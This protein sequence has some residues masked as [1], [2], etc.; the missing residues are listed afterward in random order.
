MNEAL[1]CYLNHDALVNYI[2][3]NVRQGWIGQLGAEINKLTEKL[4]AKQELIH[5]KKE[6]FAKMNQQMDLLR[7]R[8]KLA[9]DA[10]MQKTQVIQAWNGIPDMAM[11]EKKFADIVCMKP[12][13]GKG[14]CTILPHKMSPITMYYYGDVADSNILSK[15]SGPLVRVIDGFQQMNP[16]ELM[17]MTLIDLIGGAMSLRMDSRIKWSTRSQKN[18]VEE[19]VDDGMMLV[20]NVSELNE[21]S[22]MIERHGNMLVEYNGKHSN[23]VR[24][25]LGNSGTISGIAQANQIRTEESLKPFPY[26][27]VFI[28]VP[29]ANERDEFSYGQ[30]ALQRF[31]QDENISKAYGILPVFIVNKDS[32]HES[33]KRIV[34]HNGV[35]VTLEPEGDSYHALSVYRSK[36]KLSGRLLLQPDRRKG[37][38]DKSSGVLQQQCTL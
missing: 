20:S 4:N 18:F 29:R 33:W 15:I 2:K 34:E 24:A 25:L 35:K 31:I 30:Q 3:K 9:H 10:V 36:Q 22:Q 21:F 26:Q 19:G 14:Y 12:E 1:Y 32:V 23:Q 8:Q 5:Q 27:V 11:A 13:G 28:V 38:A 6:E 16:A 17:Q 37:R 7:G